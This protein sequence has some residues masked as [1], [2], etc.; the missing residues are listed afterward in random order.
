M[1]PALLKILPLPGLF[2]GSGKW[3]SG[4]AVGGSCIG[5]KGL[6]IGEGKIKVT[7]HKSVVAWGFLAE[8]GTVSPQAF[9]GFI[10]FYLDG[11]AVSQSIGKRHQPYPAAAK[12]V[13]KFVAQ[14]G[15]DPVAFY[16][17]IAVVENPNQFRIFSQGSD[18]A[19]EIIKQSIVPGRV[20][21]LEPGF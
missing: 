9:P 17:G 6:R 12:A 20:L 18:L 3:F 5:F 11:S 14:K 1:P 2:S 15:C 7:A 4:Q 13:L 16:L 10:G 21:D 19:K 8:I